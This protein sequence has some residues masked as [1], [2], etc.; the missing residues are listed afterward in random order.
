M[1]NH[2]PTTYYNDDDDDDFSHLG[3]ELIQITTAT[4]LLDSNIT[5]TSDDSIFDLIEMQTID[6][7]LYLRSNPDHIIF[8]HK[9]I[10]YPTSKTILN[11]AIKNSSNIIY[12]CNQT[13]TNPPSQKLHNIIHLNLPC[14]SLR[15]IGI[16]IGGLI[17]IAQLKTIINDNYCRT[18]QISNNPIHTFDITA[19]A[20][21]VQADFIENEITRYANT[22]HC[23]PETTQHLYSLYK[24]HTHPTRTNKRKQTHPIRKTP[25]GKIINKTTRSRRN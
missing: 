4:P 25:T 19:S 11:N 1:E 17:S 22:T 10:C 13:D 2:S 24:I 18:F 15:A 23:A 3:P 7:L 20:Y 6:A 5:I 16:Y 21:A 14:F 9:H 12:Q 8:K